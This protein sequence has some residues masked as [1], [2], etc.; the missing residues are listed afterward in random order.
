MDPVKLDPSSWYPTDLISGWTSLIWTE[1]HLEASEF[2]MKTGKITE[3]MALIP[4]GSFISLLDSDEV[5]VVESHTIG[6]NDKNVRELTTKGRSVEVFLERR[7]QIGPTYAQ[8]W[9][10]WSLS[11][12]Y[13]VQDA[14]SG[15]LWD[16]IA[17]PSNPKFWTSGYTINRPWGGGG[18]VFSSGVLITQNILLQVANSGGADVSDLQSTKQ[19]FVQPGAVYQ[20]F[21]DLMALGKLGIRT[22]RPRPSNGN[23]TSATGFPDGTVNKSV[24]SNPTGLRFEIYNGIVRTATPAAVNP[25]PDLNKVIFRVD[26]GHIETPQ[27]LFSKKEFFGRILVVSSYGNVLVGSGIGTDMYLGYVD[28]GNLSSIANP[29]Q[30]LNQVANTELAKARRKVMIDGAVSAV[31]PFKYGVH[32]NLGDIVTVMGEYGV[33]EDM[34]VNEYVRTQTKD[35]EKSYPTLIRPT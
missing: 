3:T 1:R 12:V 6:V 26:G 31:S 4:E 16:T 23:A 9:S 19:Y 8:P 32:Y 2:E 10:M 7:A 20:Q 22:I 5:M 14:V 27:Y 33:T 17:N 29:S 28:A 18:D 11:A 30:Y 34:Q 15:L 13:T 25:Q 35:G 21:L 24:V